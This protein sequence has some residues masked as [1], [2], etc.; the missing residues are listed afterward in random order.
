[1]SDAAVS[2]TSK[3]KQFVL[4]LLPLHL[5]FLFQ[6]Q[7]GVL[8]TCLFKND[9][10]NV[11]RSNSEKNCADILQVRKLLPLIYTCAVEQL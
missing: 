3:V 4:V 11:G 8:V 10:L 7:L 5:P 6:N 9:K 1:M 2:L